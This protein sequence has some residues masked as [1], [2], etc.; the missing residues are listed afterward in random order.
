MADTLE[1]ALYLLRQG[2]AGLAENFLAPP[3]AEG[4]Q[5]FVPNA[6]YGL[7]GLADMGTNY[8]TG[9]HLPGG[10]RSMELFQSGIDAA[11]QMAGVS[12]PTDYVENIYRIGV[13][14]VVP[15][16]KL[17][18]A[19]SLAG[20]IAR[21]TAEVLLPATQTNSKI[22]LGASIAV[23]VAASEAIAEFMP[24]P[25][26]IYHSATDAISGKPN[27]TDDFQPIPDFALNIP[28]ENTIPF[29]ARKPQIIDP[30]ISMAAD[31]FVPIDPVD[32]EKEEQEAD[33]TASIMTAGA[34]GLALLGGAVA[35]RKLIRG[36]A[37]APSELTGIVDVPDNTS[38]AAKIDAGLFDANAPTYDAVKKVDPTRLDQFQA[39]LATTV[40]PNALAARVA[41]AAFTGEL[42]NSGIRTTK[43]AT[44]L[45][46]LA[47][48]SQDELGIYNDGLIAGTKAEQMI[49]EGNHVWENQTIASLSQKW[50]DAR[51]NPNVGKL[52][53]E[54][55]NFYAA[56]RDY[57]NYGGLI[58]AARKAELDAQYRYYVPTAKQFGDDPYF[59]VFADEQAPKQITGFENLLN[60]ANLDAG[61]KPGELARPSDMHLAYLHQAIRY[62]ESNR[63][64]REFF[65]IM[66]SMP[67]GKQFAKVVGAP[68]DR[69]ITVRRNGQP[70][71]YQVANPV[72]RAALELRPAMVMP[73]VNSA[74]KLL[75]HGST[76]ALRPDFLPVGMAYETMTAAVT[77]PSH[78]SMG[79]IIQA[80]K[81]AGVGDSAATKINNAML[82]DPTIV[83][84]P[85]TGSVR[86]IY[87]ELAKRAS[88]AA[89]VSMQTN[90]TLQ[91]LLGPQGTQKLAD[92]AGRAYERSTVRLMQRYGGANSTLLEHEIKQKPV[93]DLAEIAPNFADATSSIGD[94]AKVKA[95][96]RGYHFLL[97]TMHNS[98]KIE[99]AANNLRP[100]M[101]WQ[102]QQRVMNDTR[103]LTGDTTAHGA[104]QVQQVMNNSAPYWNI[105]WQV[106]K[107]HSKAFKDHPG[108]YMTTIAAM[109]VGGAALLMEQFHDN[110]FAMADYWSW[111]PEQ[112]SEKLPIY[113]DDGEVV[114]EIPVEHQFR[115]VWSPFV[116]MFGALTGMKAG[117]PLPDAS[118]DRMRHAFYSALDGERWGSAMSDT[119]SMQDLSQGF[120]S[121]VGSFLP[122]PIGP[123]ISAPA[124]LLGI[125][126]SL[127]SP[128]EGRYQART[129]FNQ[130]I[131]AEDS[132]RVA[133]RFISG[134]VENMLHELVGSS[135]A[136]MIEA[137][138]AYIRLDDAGFDMNKALAGAKDALLEQP[139]DRLTAAGGPML[140]D[141]DKK[142]L[143][144]TAEARI[145]KDKLD[146]LTSLEKLLQQSRGDTMGRLSGQPGVDPR[147]FYVPE[148]IRGSELGTVANAL[149]PTI[150]WLNRQ[151]RP[152]IQDMFKKLDELKASPTLAGDAATRRRMENELVMQ[153]RQKYATT[154]EWLE[155]QEDALGNVLGIPD[156]RIEDIDIE[157]L[158]QQPVQ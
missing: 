13:P 32:F 79:L 152:V 111:T 109:N 108:R 119:L 137:I 41:D 18:P 54:V 98:I 97:N 3:A 67:N 123:S 1:R 89:E 127:T 52:I 125:D 66:D 146:K 102:Q 81:A 17:P 44:H 139:K 23:P 45:E 74:R 143:T 107:A 48:L 133:D 76:G 30:M 94:A 122:D 93:V 88:I 53:D 106:L 35:A 158:K 20:N 51:N 43:L 154:L 14:A 100:N 153:I 75:Q 11:N 59:K 86:G 142:M 4:V 150:Q 7:Y 71:H 90:G 149:Y 24:I 16:P 72:L 29:P 61:L 151:H 36:N 124:A 50:Q 70:I 85:L 87:G 148:N 47:K 147:T 99:F 64:R 83:L 6:L 33:I 114:W 128:L 141:W 140:W 56:M 95:L 144:N 136:P 131:N 134:N 10:E 112:R 92:I 101:S 34:V 49:R 117:V 62:V 69:T 145:I 110:I 63:I 104:W 12:D 135:A 130:R 138:D 155:E 118:V 116:E 113:N 77:R 157:A 38:M 28:T 42:P 58:S 15:L 21:T 129:L 46:T 25:D 80:L 126:P 84:A 40:T 96:W 31:G 68:N 156:F 78:R 105:F 8:I 91:K 57:M 19:S 60:R 82:V 121:A 26:E 22:A 103:K 9:K 65:D 120:K 73:I 115:L 5:K 37:P 27:I 39:D 55:H 2:G 132:G